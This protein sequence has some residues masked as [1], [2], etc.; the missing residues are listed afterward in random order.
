[1]PRK[2]R[3]MMIIII[4]VVVVLILALAWGLLYLNTDMFKSN[5]TLFAKYIGKNMENIENFET[6]SNEEKEYNGL[7]ENNKYTTNLEATVNY[8][9]DVGTTLENTNNAINKLKITSDGQVDKANQYNYQNIKLLNNSESALELEYIQSENTYGIRFSDLFKQFTLV[10]NSNLKELASKLGIKDEQLESIHDQI[11]IENDFS[12]IFNFS[13]AEKQ[14]LQNKYSKIFEQNI[15]KDKFTKQ[16]DVT[17]TVNDKNVQTNAYTL[18]LT[19]EELNNI[20]I[21]ILEIL[22]QDEVILVKLDNLQNLLN[23]YSINSSETSQ[24]DLRNEFTKSIT[25][26]IE[27]IENNNIGT[28]ETKII[29]YENR[30]N[31]IR[32]MVQ[33]DKDEVT[34]DYYKNGSE[35]YSQFSN[36]DLS[37]TDNNTEKITYTNN[38]K[39]INLSYSSKVGENTKTYTLNQKNEIADSKSIKNIKVSYLDNSNK[40]ELAINEN[41]NIVNSFSDEI[42]LDDT[43]S[44]KINDLESEKLNLL[45]STMQ[46]AITNKMSEVSTAINFNDVYNVLKVIGLVQETPTIENTGVTTEAEKNRYN[47]QFELFAGEKL[48]SDYVVQMLDG[49]KN[50]LVDLEVVNNSELKIN[51]SKSSQNEELLGSLKDLIEK[52]KNKEYSIKMVYNDVSGL[53][54]SIIVKIESE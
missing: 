15:S 49:I 21:K 31:T 20:F 54:E 22:Q 11:N 40:V 37:T 7:L 17:I 29:V 12:N 8:T 43:N 30:H 25:D 41:T 48:K 45:V 5:Q 51:I 16:S 32:T 47:S 39:E 19:K 4:A 6:V 23:T 52:N 3:R 9:Q 10:E 46:E 50:N 24:S 28:E 34:F 33:T 38:Q 42:K 18:T 27:K 44:V 35:I 2:K 14:S 26:T 36:E 53:V 1:M 13:E